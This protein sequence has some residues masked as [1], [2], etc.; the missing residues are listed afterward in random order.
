MLC[1]LAWSNR[2]ISVT[3]SEEY[4]R[5]RRI[6]RAQGA[7]FIASSILITTLSWSM[8][9]TVSILLCVLAL[10]YLVAVGLLPKWVR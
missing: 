2:L 4:K 9:W 10:I 7:V 5:K 3:S 1:S 8:K 6:A